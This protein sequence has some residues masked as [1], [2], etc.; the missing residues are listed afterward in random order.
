MDEISQAQTQQLNEVL[1]SALDD[2]SCEDLMSMN[3]Y[4]LKYERPL[5]VSEL[6]SNLQEKY[7]FELELSLYK[8]LGIPETQIRYREKNHSST[9]RQIYALKNA[10]LLREFLNTF[11]LESGEI[12]WEK[13]VEFNS[14]K[15]T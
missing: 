3:S 8:K 7:F 15:E 6:I 12:D 11:C 9:F 4:L 2:I 13:L 1:V 10:T 14:G 5:V